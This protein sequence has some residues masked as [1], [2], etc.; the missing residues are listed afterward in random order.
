MNW[1]LVDA[2]SAAC[3]LIHA[4]LPRYHRDLARSLNEIGKT[5]ADIKALVVT[6]GHI[7]HVGMAPYL[8]DAGT[9]VYLHEADVSL[10]GY[11]GSNRTERNPLPYLRYPG[12]AGFVGHAILNGA[13]KPE[14]P[15]PPTR[16]LVEGANPAIPGSPVVTHTPGHTDASCVIEFEEQ[17]RARRRPAL[18]GQPHHRQARAAPAADQRFRQEQLAGDEVARPPRGHGVP[19]DT[20]GARATLDRWDRGGRSERAEDR[21]PLTRL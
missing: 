6:H 18:H 2:G 5:P 17:D 21:L 7:D 10:A 1:Y 16:P 8:A 4:G 13:L 19:S 15:M 11:P 14:R 12:I 9:V 20:A 3:V